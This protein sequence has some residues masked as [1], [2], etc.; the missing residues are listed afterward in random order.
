MAADSSVSL[1]ADLSVLRRELAK[2]PNLTATEAQKMLVA[3]E[4]QVDKAE[5]VAK[6][7]ARQVGQANKRA[8]REAEK[9][10]EAAQQGAKGLA[11]LAGLSGDKFDKLGAVIG[12][13][14]TPVGMLTLGIT[15]A[16][17]A[18]AGLAAGIVGIVRASEELNKATA[19]Y[20]EI[21]GFGGLPAGA[22]AS[23]EAANDAMDSMSI[24][25]KRV[26]VLLAA[27]FAPAVEQAARVGLKLSLVMLDQVQ[28][29]LDGAS[30][31]EALAVFLTQKLV[32]AFLAPVDGLVTMVGLLGD[33]AN[34]VGADELGGA[35]NGVEKAWDGWTKTV[36][37]SAV[38]FHVDAVAGAVGRVDQ[39]T[40]DYDA[41]VEQLLGTTRGLKNMTADAAA[42]MQRLQ[43]AAGEWQKRL[44]VAAK[45]E[46][47]VA[48]Q[49][50]L[51]EISELEQA[52]ALNAT[53]AGAARVLAQ[54]DYQ[55]ALDAEAEAHA[56]LTAQREEAAAKAHELINNLTSHR[57][58]AIEQIDL[59]EEASLRNVEAA[60]ARRRELAGANV[61]ELVAIE[62][63]GQEAR[64]LVEEEYAQRRADL[65]AEEA[66]RQAESAA[67][68]M[69]S[70]AGDFLRSLDSLAEAAGQKHSDQITALQEQLAAG[71]KT[72]STAEQKRIREKIA[73][74]KKA[75]R[76]AF[77]MQKAL[78][79]VQIA[80]Q[81]SVAV[82]TALAQLG[83][84]A[85][86][87]AAAF[88]TATG[89]AQAAVVVSKQP[90]FHMGRVPGTTTPDP[91]PRSNRPGETTATLTDTEGVVAPS[92]MD[93]LAKLNRGEMPGG[94]SVTLRLRHQVIDE[95]AGDAARRPGSELWQLTY[96][97]QDVG[98]RAR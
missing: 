78:A 70:I 23:I 51:K 84:I 47:L 52:G 56:R 39:A 17:L 83:P 97:E 31:G 55:A 59:A 61:A 98:R 89:I 33:L 53:D 35:L 81:T 92:G 42:S 43:Q 76:N 79:L 38:D 7:A 46:A 67:Q 88:I 21:A 13:T 41:R 44:E 15:G 12:A 91:G 82:M 2:L 68:L 10:A 5:R 73:A 40:A 77:R 62:R 64:A 18:T 71:E 11:E 45:G 80:M 32:K 86:G 48:L 19:P 36:A 50:Q 30:A 4:K 25:G 65:Y 22:L 58:G 49:A 69:T 16:T 37:E 27:E 20:E 8:M 60:M 14:G 74:E 90:E 54:K 9:A 29:F 96:G 75:A 1:G 93:A 6:N 72:L 57:L 87:V 95:I 63:E 94:F 66:R 24:V 3:L 34:V 26:V 85:G 28:A